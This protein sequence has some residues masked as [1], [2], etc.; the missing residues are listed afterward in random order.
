MVVSQDVGRLVVRDEM[1]GRVKREKK[2]QIKFLKK[3]T[4]PPSNSENFFLALGARE[5][6]I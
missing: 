5:S 6:C 4:N 2:K 3:E 1:I